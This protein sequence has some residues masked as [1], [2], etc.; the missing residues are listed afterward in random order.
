MLLRSRRRWRDIQRR[1]RAVALSVC[2]W[3]DVKMQPW[4]LILGESKNEDS[5]HSAEGSSATDSGRGA[6][7][8]GGGGDGRPARYIPPPPPPATAPRGAPY[9]AV[10]QQQLPSCAPSSSSSSSSSSHTLPSR[11]LLRSARKQTA[12]PGAQHPYPTSTRGT[13]RFKGL[14][15]TPEEDADEVEMTTT[16]TLPSTA[17]SSALC[18]GLP[19][20]GGPCGARGCPPPPPARARVDAASTSTPSRI[21][22]PASLSSSAPTSSSRS[23]CIFVTTSRSLDV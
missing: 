22:L 5:P 2:M 13:V 12:A 18:D 20:N 15:T 6:S 4:T 14:N 11:P 3:V 8:E 9:W 10:H 21:V 1:G 16:M 7:D 17:R 19:R 23:P